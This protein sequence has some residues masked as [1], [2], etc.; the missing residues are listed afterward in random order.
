ME[1]SFTRISRILSCVTLNIAYASPHAYTPTPHSFRLVE[2]FLSNTSCSSGVFSGSQRPVAHLQ[3]KSFG[4]G[5][6]LQ[7]KSPLC[8]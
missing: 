3:L 7:W 5:L 8:V 1:R 2:Y 6:F 4:S